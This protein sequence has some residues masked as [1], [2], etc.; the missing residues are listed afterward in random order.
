MERGKIPSH[1]HGQSLTSYNTQHL[2]GA[3]TDKLWQ[4]RNGKETASVQPAPPQTSSIQ[5][6]NITGTNCL[7]D[8]QKQIDTFYMYTD[9][10]F[11]V[12]KDI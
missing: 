9:L 10:W 11:K 6:L 1:N 7:L 2:G 4:P 8:K 12:K 5:I 3:K